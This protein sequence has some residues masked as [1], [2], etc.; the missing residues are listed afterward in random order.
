MKILITNDN[1]SAHMWIREGWKNAFNFAGH[2]CYVWNMWDGQACFDVF[3][4]FQPDVLITQVYNLNRE[5]FKCI[6]NRPHLKVLMKSPDFGALTEN[7][8]EEYPI[9]YMSNEQ[10]E[11]LELLRS[12]TGQP[13]FLFV[14]YPEDRLYETHGYLTDRGFKV[15]SLLNAADVIK[16]S[17]PTVDN[18]LSCD[19]GFIGGYWPFKA[20]VLD[21]YLI[22]ICQD[23]RYN[24][25]IFGNAHW[26][27]PQYCG[28][29]PTEKEKDLFISSSI[30]LNLHEPHSEDHG[31]DIT[32]KIF[33]IGCSGGF[34][35]SDFVSGLEKLF[36]F[37]PYFKNLDEM[38]NKIDYYL[39]NKN[40]RIEIT[41]LLQKEIYQKH[42]YFHRCK[43][44]LS[45]LEL[46][47][48]LIDNVLRKMHG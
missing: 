29:L 6:E 10:L 48:T 5:I 13:N 31:Y 39:S 2:S 47:T 7:L 1:Q 37:I 40:E 42:T 27:V 34:V 19:I 38:I 23:Y 12:R 44:I 18:R 14:H 43:T 11:T 15:V 26:P 35:I 16:Y 30:N 9:L 32:E 8:R 22:N 36:P 33:K 24:I 46:D 4:K 21:K 17:N 25:K 28:F 20:Q 45:E 3:N 41:N